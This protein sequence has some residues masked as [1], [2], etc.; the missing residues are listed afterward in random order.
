MIL[1]W[2]L[3]WS[4]LSLVFIIL[5]HHL[6]NFF[7]DT[8]TFPKVK[9]LVYKP[10]ERYQHLLHNLNKIQSQ[11]E[12]IEPSSRIS[13]GITG[14]NDIMDTQTTMK[15]E[16]LDFLDQIKKHPEPTSQLNKDNISWSNIMNSNSSSN[17]HPLIQS[18][19]IE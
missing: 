19:P 8:L 13:T 1:L 6:Y 4:T 2:T 10:N 14:M 3:K 18:T 7:M 17:T 15:T 12:T 11:P 16:L 9:D 5:L